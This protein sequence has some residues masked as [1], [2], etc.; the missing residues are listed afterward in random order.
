MK[1][2]K[3]LKGI[4]VLNA[5]Q[6]KNVT[7][8]NISNKTTN[9]LKQGLYICIK[10][11]NTD[12]HSLKNE[13]LKCGAVAFI[14]E[15]IDYEFDG[16]QILV[17][18]SRKAMSIIAKNFYY[19]KNFPK[20]I[21]ITG[22]NGKTTTTSLVAHILKEQGKSVALIGTEGIYFEDK[23]IN[24]HMTTPDPIDLFRVLN[25]M[26]QAEVEYAVMEVSAHA[27]FLEKICSLDFYVKALTNI[28][29]DHLDFFESFTKYK[30]TKLDFIAAKKGIKIVNIDDKYGCTLAS[31]VSKMFTYSKSL[32]A[33]IFASEIDE[34]CQN[35]AVNLDKKH[36]HI[37]TNL[38]GSYNIEN[39][40]CAFLIC[41]K[42]G[43]SEESI[44]NA[45][46]TFKAVDGRLNVYKKGDITAV[47][48]FA[49]TPDALEKVL[50]TVRPTC[51]CKLICVFGCG[52][53]R[54]ALKRPIM[55]KIASKN[56]D[57]VYVTSDNPRYE[58]PDFIAR[59]IVSDINGDNYKIVHD[60][61][62]AVLD[63]FEMCNDGDM[64]VLCGK[65]AEDYIEIKGV[66]H[67]YSD[68][69]TL[70]D[71]GFERI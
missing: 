36:L 14:V 49:H 57:F 19:N 40:L 25:A 47:I 31:K 48:D 24:L 44:A 45:L 28:T 53:N 56:A 32:P 69:Q 10:G 2:K 70:I 51:K 17:E 64:L 33:D 50:K 65:G 9:E 12:G 42:L 55:G 68:M 66:K 4:K 21:G 38:I 11:Q 41:K 61:K 59:Q 71:L 13:A 6:V 37:K 15:E 46:L 35:Y 52:G 3:L 26:A 39:V 20:I 67:T 43:L 58:E 1:L 23:K 5:R 63:A 54:D 27:I 22:T 62:Q 30:N 29:E 18:D 8:E 60:R 7:I 16:M 34:N